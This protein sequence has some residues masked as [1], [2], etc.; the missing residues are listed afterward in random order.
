MI[1][2]YVVVA[3]AVL[4]AFREAAPYVVAL[5]E[6]P[7]CANEDGEPV[8][9]AGLLLDGEEA[10]G[11]GAT[12]EVAWEEAP[13]GAYTVPAWRALG[14]AGGEMWRLDADLERAEAPA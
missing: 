6:L 7:D 11:V 1:A 4:P 2:S 12:V 9:I 8:R 10:A 13:D 5:V 3:H 14:D